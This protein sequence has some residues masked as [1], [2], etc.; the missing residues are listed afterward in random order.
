[1]STK[2]NKRKLLIYSESFQ[3]EVKFFKTPKYFWYIN[4]EDDGTT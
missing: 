3:K 2:T 4:V 1:M